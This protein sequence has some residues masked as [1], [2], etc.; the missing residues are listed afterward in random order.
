MMLGLFL[1]IFTDNLTQVVKRPPK[2]T[3]TIT[4]QNMPDPLAA[5]RVKW[6]VSHLPPIDYVFQ[7]PKIPYLPIMLT[8]VESNWR[9]S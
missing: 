9:L 3:Y 8:L 2:L 6:R 4:S 1:K 5:V 7:F